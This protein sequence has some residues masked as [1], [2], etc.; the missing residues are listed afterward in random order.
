MPNLQSRGVHSAFE[1]KTKKNRFEQQGSPHK[2][3]EEQIFTGNI[4]LSFCE[5]EDPANNPDH[6][7]K[8]PNIA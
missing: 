7:Q 8:Y 1:L 4:V 2:I 6:H 5:W 3:E